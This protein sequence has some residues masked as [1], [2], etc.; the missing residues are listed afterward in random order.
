M[1]FADADDGWQFPL[2]DEIS[3]RLFAWCLEYAVDLVFR[4][5]AL[6]PLDFGRNA[7]KGGAGSPHGLVLLERAQLAKTGYFF[8]DHEFGHD[9]ASLRRV[10]LLSYWF[11][12]VPMGRTKIP[13]IDF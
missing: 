5:I 10:T 13:A 11:A 9:A 8:L 4:K 1:H 3:K 12:G 7:M 2:L 6:D